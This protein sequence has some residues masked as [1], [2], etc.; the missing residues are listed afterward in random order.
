LEAAL[1]LGAI[2]GPEHT[3]PH[4]AVMRQAGNQPIQQ[5]G[6]EFT[7]KL[8]AKSWR[9]VRRPLMNIHDELLIGKAPS[10]RPDFFPKLNWGEI[11]EMV[12][13][14]LRHGRQMVKS[15]S[16]KIKPMEKWSDKE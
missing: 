14:F 15:L 7:K 3:E 10:S 5:T 13:E 4:G 9:T 1:Q 6:S 2:E 12:G 8:M 11:D 16:I